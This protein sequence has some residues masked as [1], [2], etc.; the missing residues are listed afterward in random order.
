[1]EE[2]SESS[3]WQAIDDA[4]QVSQLLMHL[5]TWQTAWKRLTP[6]VIS[7]AVQDGHSFR[8]VLEDSDRETGYKLLQSCNLISCDAVR[9]GLR[10]KCLEAAHHKPDI[11]LPKLCQEG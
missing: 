6:L 9:S 5:H 11:R 1:M 8:S 7:V 10:P 4:V 2:S 3:A